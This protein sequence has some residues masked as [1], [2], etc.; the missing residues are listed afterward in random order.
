MFD[1]ISFYKYKFI[2]EP[3]DEIVFSSFKEYDF[4]YAL[5]SAFKKIFCSQGKTKCPE[6]VL[7]DVCI[8]SKL[9]I[10]PHPFVIEPPAERK[11]VYKHGDSITFNVILI[12][13]MAEFITYF[14]LSVKEFESIGI[15]KNRGRFR[16]KSVHSVDS[17]GEN[18]KQLYSDADDLIREYDYLAAGKDMSGYRN[19]VQI[20]D[21][22]TIKFE[23]L[24]RDSGCRPG[25]E[26]C[27]IFAGLIER[28]EALRY[29]TGQTCGEPV[30]DIQEIQSN[31]REII[32]VS[33]QVRW[34]D[35]GR[36]SNKQGVSPAGGGILGSLTFEGKFDNLM[37]FLVMGE[38]LH[39]GQDC[40]F[41][42][43]K[44]KLLI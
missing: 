10:P 7:S 30:L 31:A 28:M 5:S 36:F 2:I 20:P 32:K 39:V 22:V 35:W 42:L 11:K 8:C 14:I 9:F 13:Q 21:R 15:G 17:C 27:D 25:L 43:G 26:F 40:C 44:Y 41:G 33:D 23:T 24:Y 37:D 16:L 12:G 6:C 1:F 29:C 34:V 38:Q 19:I 3:E 4:K 18:D